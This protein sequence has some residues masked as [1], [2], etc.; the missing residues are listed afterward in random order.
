[1]SEYT[2]DI[3]ARI[4]ANKELSDI[5]LSQQNLLVDLQASAQVSHYDLLTAIFTP[6]NV[7]GTVGGT[8]IASPVGGEAVSIGLNVAEGLAA[9]GANQANLSLDQNALNSDEISLINCS[10]ISRLI[11]ANTAAAFRAM[12]QGQPPSTL[13]GTIIG[14]QSVQ[15]YKP[16]TGFI[17]NLETWVGQTVANT[18]YVTV[19]RAYS[20]ATV[21]NT[22]KEPA[23]F[24]IHAIYWHTIAINDQLGNALQ[25]QTIPMVTAST[26]SIDSGQSAQM[27]LNYFDG[28]SGSAPDIGSPIN[29]YLLAYDLNDSIYAIDSNTSTTQWQ[30]D[31]SGGPTPMGNGPDTN[32]F[33]VGNPI[34]SYVYPSRT[35]Y[36]YEATIQIVNPF[37]IPLLATVTQPL[38]TGIRVLS[39]DG[40]LG[41]SSIVWTN[42]VL[43]NSLVQNT[44]TFELSSTPSAQTN[45]PAAT[46][47]FSDGTGTNSLSIQSSQPS[48]M[49][50]FPVQASGSIPQGLP[51]VASV[52]P[53]VVT[54]LMS[55]N[56]SGLL[57][58]TL[59]DASG[60]MVTN[61]AQRFL[62]N[63]F[64]STN[65]IFSL[66]KNLS[67]GSYLLN[68][69]LSIDGRT[70]PVLSGLY[71]V[72]V[73]P[74]VLGV[75]PSFPLSTNGVSL[76]I[77]GPT[78]SNLLIEATYD[79]SNSANWKPVGYFTMTNSPSYFIDASATNLS[80]RFYRVLIP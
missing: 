40:V 79:L 39:T 50:L 18:E 7:V 80:S 71:S 46:L 48:F 59:T 17:G 1:M 27:T 62:V 45:L 9:Y 55:T 29:V 68:A 8:L 13:T 52:M 53:L 10:H 44:F 75:G 51:G 60:N 16:L 65:V 32:S 58:I 2:K 12:S 5:A 56:Q 15:A 26:T 74:V 54:N 63:G 33:S 36:S 20:T 77:R 19:T 41:T 38:P 25:Y 64:S 21:M 49:G 57:N 28:V 70:G 78:S 14:L 31:T 4:L 37:V 24:T 61:V 69:S 67:P 23:L 47:V 22:S 35:N 73:A 43:T 42:T 76:T 30:L 34:T 66:P 3:T 72:P 11:S 6:I